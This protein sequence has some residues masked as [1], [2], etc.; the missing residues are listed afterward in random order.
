MSGVSGSGKSTHA[1]KILNKTQG[2]KVSADHF[3]MKENGTYA[4]DVTK[5]G[6]AHADCFRRFIEFVSFAPNVALL[7]SDENNVVVVDNT[8]CTEAEISPYMLG[9]G[10]FG[11]DAEIITIVS[12]FAIDDSKRLHHLTNADN[13]QKGYISEYIDMCAK[14]NAH[15]VTRKIIENQWYRLS[16]RHLPPYWSHE[17]IYQ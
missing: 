1:E 14:R 4:F 9:A 13:T 5:L 3:F 11:W 2:V 12:P 15:A 16:H 17:F 7:E 8:N 10:A 6:L